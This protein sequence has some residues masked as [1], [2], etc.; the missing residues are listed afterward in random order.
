MAVSYS[1]H[2]K[3]PL[4][5]PTAMAASYLAHPKIFLRWVADAEDGITIST[6]APPPLPPSPPPDADGDESIVFST[7]E[8][9]QIPTMTTA[10]YSRIWTLNLH[11]LP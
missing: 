7:L 1:A 4:P 10:S 11:K 6:P 9:T 8:N 2:P 5:T 3:P